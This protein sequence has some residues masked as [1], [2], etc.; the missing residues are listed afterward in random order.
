M[1]LFLSRA[2]L[3]SDAPVAA[4]RGLLLP[5]DES[6]RV[7][8]AHRLVWALFSDGPDRRR[9]FLWREASPGLFFLLSS[10]APTDPHQ[11]FEL[12]EPKSFAPILRAGDVLA[13][14]LRANATIA[15]V[16]GKNVR[17]KPEDVVMHALHALGP[18]D[19]AV[20]RTEMVATAGYAWLLRQ[21]ERAGF[22]FAKPSDCRVAAHRV[23][24][25]SRPGKPARMGVLDLEGRLVVQDP[26]RFLDALATGF[27]RGKAFGNGLMLIRRA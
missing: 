6:A 13:F 18:A 12:D 10:R 15:R 8:T 23:L 14:S 9:D 20:Q 19:R 7:T 17:G 25:L 4:L 11:M 21:G 16:L 26:S 2:R 3:R 22:A 5:D 24:S 1:S 27:G